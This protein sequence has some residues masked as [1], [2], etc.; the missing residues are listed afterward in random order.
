MNR[1]LE[2]G[3]PTASPPSPDAIAWLDPDPSTVDITVHG[4]WHEFRVRADVN[5]YFNDHVGVF[6][7]GQVDGALTSSGNSPP[8]QTVEEVCEDEFYDGLNW[9]RAINQAFHLAICKEGEA[10]IQVRHETD[11]VPA[12]AEYSFTVGSVL[13]LRRLDPLPPQ[14]HGRLHR[15]YQPP[16]RCR[17]RHLPPP[18]AGSAALAPLRWRLHFA[19]DFGP[20]GTSPRTPRRERPSAS[21]LSRRTRATWISSTQ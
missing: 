9:R 11:P 20:R 6:G 1:Y 21:R 14:R 13:R 15:L 17:R 2:V 19:T 3:V 16:L 4:E 5:K 10:T 7:F 12:L 8:P 18:A